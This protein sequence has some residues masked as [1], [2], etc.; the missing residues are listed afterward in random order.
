VTPSAKPG[1]V[2]YTDGNCDC[3]HPTKDDE[4]G[5]AIRTPKLAAP[6][7]A[8]KDEPPGI[9]GKF[10][11]T[12]HCDSECLSHFQKIGREGNLPKCAVGTHVKEGSVQQKPSTSGDEPLY[13]WTC[14]PDNPTAETQPRSKQHSK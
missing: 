6:P 8:T 3:A 4:C 1:C 9:S 13:S 10:D 5:A 7:V 2:I 11:P 14:T 12:Y